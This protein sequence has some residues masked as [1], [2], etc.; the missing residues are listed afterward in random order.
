[1]PKVSV[2]IPNYNHA[3]FLEQR[4]DSVLAQSFKDYEVIILDDCSTDNSK[5]VIERY[6]NHFKVSH[7]VYNTKNSGSPFS[8]WRKGVELAEGKYI[9]IAESDDYS[10]TLFL[11]TL[12]PEFTDANVGIAFCS[13]HWID[14]FGLIKDDLSIY[15]KSFKASGQKIYINEMVYN[16]TIQNVSSAI[17]RKSVISNLLNKLTTFK[18]CG[19]W[20]LYSDILTRSILSFNESKLNYFRWYHN[21]TS[22]QAVKL[23]KW[24]D[25]GVHVL[26]FL[27]QSKSLT[28]GKIFNLYK[29][30]NRRINN[31]NDYI[32][33]VKIKKYLLFYCSKGVFSTF[34]KYK[35]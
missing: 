7:I 12:L 21:N 14:D 35:Q 18:Y 5:D 31:I 32:R 11:E 4:I 13:S 9:W 8:Q 15:K 22:N 28:L 16:C 23:G 3:R 20:I 24:T 33:R 2:I 17:I 27:P 25:E 26:Q 29:F 6:R 1:M 30:W 10:D 34:L 19:D